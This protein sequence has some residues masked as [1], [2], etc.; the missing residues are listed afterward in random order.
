MSCMC[1]DSKLSSHLTNHFTVSVNAHFDIGG[2]FS[3]FFISVFNIKIKLSATGTA[4]T[5][6]EGSRTIP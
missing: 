3:L 4:A 1:I 5:L 2:K 6:T